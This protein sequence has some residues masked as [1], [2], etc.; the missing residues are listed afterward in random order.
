MPYLRHQPPGFVFMVHPRDV[1]D[2]YNVRGSSVVAQ[3][4]ASEEEFRDKMLSLPPTITGEVTFGFDAVRGE[5]LAVL[6]LPGQ[7]M[8]SADRKSV[9]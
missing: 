9:V 7:I 3:H 5:L 2:L 1:A 4:S 8:Y 6:C